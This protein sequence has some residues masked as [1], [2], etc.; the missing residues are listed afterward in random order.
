MTDV[1]HRV[2]AVE[3]RLESAFALDARLKTIE[4]DL[5]KLKGG[6]SLRD[7][8]QT[9]GPYIGGLI[10]LFVGF[11]IKDSVTLA[12]QREQLDLSYVQ[13]MRDLIKDFDESNTQ[14]AADANAVGLAMYGKYAVLPLVERLEVGG[15]VVPLA[16]QRGLRLVGIEHAADAC[17]KFRAVINDRARR[18]KW[19][20]HKTLIKVIGQS[21]CPDARAD[22]ESYRAA[23]AQLG[24]DDTRLH[25]FAQR[26]SVE[27]GFDAESVAALKVEIERALAIISPQV[28]T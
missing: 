2:A 1:E 6:S 10:V 11:W 14:A 25:A 8:L 12:L 7:W 5:R 4:G 3:A 23:L 19:Q 28:K 22:L 20:T 26:Y 16:A 15:D 17:P 21:E 18:F 9:L 24:S 13:Q 27:E